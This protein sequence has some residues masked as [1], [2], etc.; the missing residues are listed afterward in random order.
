MIH[1]IENNYLK[2]A[3]QQLGAEIC[4]IK[5]QKTGK[6][7]LWD[8]NP[9]IWGSHSPVLFPIIGALKNN[10]FSYQGKSYSVPKHGFIRNNSQLEID[11]KTTEVLVL[12]YKYNEESL[13]MYPF[14]FVFYISFHLHKNKLI[15]THKVENIGE[16]EMYFSVGAH[17]AFKCPINSNENYEDYYIEFEAMETAQ[18]WELASGGLTSGKTHMVLENSNKLHLTKQLFA[19]DA[20][21]FKNLKSKKVSLKSNVNNNKISLH[22][23][24][25]NYLGIWAKPNA[26]FVCIEPWL[27]ITDDI[28]STGEIEHKEGILNLETKKSFTAEYSIVIDEE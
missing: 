10:S 13:K 22:F 27:G 4:S 23:S 18:T 20:L 16:N 24:D 28:N 19:N 7:F 21:I 15:I 12:K 26:P 14:K 9:D 8:A 25:F 2:V 1:T 3:V 5:S 17:P 11:S 6:E